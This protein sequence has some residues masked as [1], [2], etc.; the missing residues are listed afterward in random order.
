MI[1]GVEVEEVAPVE[2]FP[3]LLEGAE[4]QILPIHIPGELV[5]QLQIEE[6]DRIVCRVRRVGL[7]RYFVHKQEITIE[8]PDDL[9]D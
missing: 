7:D 8:S 9:P 1:A 2:G 5:E 4:G 6:L 3:N